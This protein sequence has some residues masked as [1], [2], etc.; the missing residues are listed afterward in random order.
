[1]IDWLLL[2]YNFRKCLIM[3]IYLTHVYF[4][5][6]TFDDENDIFKLD[7]RKLNWSVSDDCLLLIN[8]FKKWYESKLISM[9]MMMLFILCSFIRLEFIL[10][11]W[12]MIFQ[13]RFC[14]VFLIDMRWRIRCYDDW[15][16][17][18]NKFNVEL[19]KHWISYAYSR[20]K[21]SH[22][23]VLRYS[24]KLIHQSSKL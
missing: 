4:I 11:V 7:L 20:A 23:L 9:S 2:I 1:M 17:H 16:S 5:N 22:A 21:S 14:F 12:S 19:I 15:R 3:M 13:S 18:V 10:Y 6:R 24:K 8:I